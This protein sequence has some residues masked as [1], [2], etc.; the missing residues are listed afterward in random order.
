MLDDVLRLA[1][2]IFRTGSPVAIIG[3]LLLVVMAVLATAYSNTSQG[4]PQWTKIVIAFAVIG[5][6]I[7]FLN[8]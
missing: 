7:Y 1:D 5:G 8:S 6:L 2:D 4:A 3:F